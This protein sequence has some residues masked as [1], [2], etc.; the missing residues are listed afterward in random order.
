MGLQ[1]VI[2]DKR[3]LGLRA[4]DFGFWLLRFRVEGAG[5]KGFQGLGLRV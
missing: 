4:Q 1:V 2:D 5:I 3:G